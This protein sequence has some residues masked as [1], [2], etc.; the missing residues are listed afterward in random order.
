[1]T[2]LGQETM[3]GSNATT[4]TKAVIISLDVLHL[5][6]LKRREVFELIE[7]REA[8]W[9]TPR[10]REIGCW[11]T[12]T[13]RSSG[14]SASS[15]ELG[16]LLERSQELWDIAHRAKRVC[17]L[18]EYDDIDNV[19]TSLKALGL[20]IQMRLGI[21][22][23]KMRD[24]TPVRVAVRNALSELRPTPALFGDAMKDC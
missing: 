5:A 7:E 20:P 10:P 17:P 14:Y 24:L 11:V 18:V 13:I 21:H 19:V 23:G 3:T 22:G 15:D 6:A 4:A 2:P 8:I 9:L 1:M 12:A 16:K